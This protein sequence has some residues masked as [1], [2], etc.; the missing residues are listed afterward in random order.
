MRDVAVPLHDRERIVCQQPRNYIGIGE[1]CA[2][3]TSNDGGAR[4]GRTQRAGLAASGKSSGNVA[5]SEQGLS[6]Q[7]AHNSVC[8][9]IHVPDYFAVSG[10]EFRCAPKRGVSLLTDSNR[11]RQRLG[12]LRCG[13]HVALPV[14]YSARF[15]HETRG[16][17]LA[18]DDA[19]RLD[20][21][22]AF[23][24]N[25]AIEFPGNH[26]VIPFDLPFHSRPLAQDQAVT[27]N[28]V[29]FYVRIDAKYARSLQSSLEAHAL[30]EEA[31]KF[32]LLRVLA[33]FFRSPLH[34]VPPAE[35]ELC[36]NTI[37]PEHGK[38]ESQNHGSVT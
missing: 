4:G 38:F 12:G 27:G 28:H 34:S 33:T 8:D 10:T 21:H 36:G 18:H 37:L 20:F 2:E 26:H 15:D 23:G 19:L 6:Y 24:K 5:A 31:C 14:E 22:P 3:G 13:Q 30:V 11:Y 25:D 29:S 1:H 17:D 7:C 16:M 9:R 35:T 32:V